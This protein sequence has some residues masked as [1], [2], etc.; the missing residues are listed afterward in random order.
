MVLSL[1]CF[2]RVDLFI[3]LAFQLLYYFS[4][5][6]YLNTVAQSTTFLCSNCQLIRPMGNLLSNATRHSEFEIVTSRVRPYFW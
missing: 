5:H 6:Q 1:F 4:F 3:N 2:V